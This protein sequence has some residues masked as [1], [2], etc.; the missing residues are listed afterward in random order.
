MRWIDLSHTLRTGMDQYPGD[1]RPVRL[2]R[3]AMHD[4]DPYMATSLEMG[5]HV[6]THVDAPL[7][8]GPGQAGVDDLPLAAFAGLARV[9][10]VSGAVPSGPL[11]PATMPADGCAGVEFLLLRT[12]WSRHWGTSR[13]YAGWPWLTA[14]LAAH[15]AAA[16][17][18]GVGID[19]PSI[20]DL[21]RREAHD[22]FAAAGMIIV[23]N[24]TGLDALPAGPFLFVALPLKLQG[25]EASP[26]R[27]A[28]LLEWPQLV[29][30]PVR[31]TGRR[32]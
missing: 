31:P 2:I 6:G 12:G 11:T 13:Y 7:H 5:C 32:P 14:D 18:K 28:A 19:G 30:L 15:L 16:G 27:A 9:I 26:V 17:L 1:P 10:D 29:D 4:A 20:D 25:T 22:V 21:D 24:L 3:Q 23:E 8:F